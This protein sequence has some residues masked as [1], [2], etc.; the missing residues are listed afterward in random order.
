MVASCDS[1]IHVWDPWC[2]GRLLSSMNSIPVNILKC[3]PTPHPN[4]LAAS[5][6]PT[7]HSIDPRN[8]KSVA[9]LKV[10]TLILYSIILYL[11]IYS[12]NNSLY[13]YL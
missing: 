6:H 1:S 10:R 8:G 7:L 4:I 2:G 3:L 11:L 13:R 9:E 12:L 5:T